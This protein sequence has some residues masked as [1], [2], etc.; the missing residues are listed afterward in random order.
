MP[1]DGTRL[2]RFATSDDITEI[3]RKLDSILDFHRQ[4]GPY[5]PMLTRL[6]AALD[7]PAARFRTRRP[8]RA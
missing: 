8:P 5:L 1:A 6:A 4:L 2:V 3:N 7:N